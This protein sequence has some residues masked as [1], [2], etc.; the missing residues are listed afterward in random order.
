MAIDNP[1][2]PCTGESIKPFTFTRASTISGGEL[3]CSMPICP[4]GAFGENF[5]SSGILEDQIKIGDR[6]RV[7]S[8][9]FLVTQPRMPASNLGS[10]LIVATS[11]NV[12][13]RANA[14]DFTWP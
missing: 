9:E 11:R 7:G 2:L 5:S 1:I 14:P 10:D 6:I 13:F 12:S 4:G 8:A 3:N